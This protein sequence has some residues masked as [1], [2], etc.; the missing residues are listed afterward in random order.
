M[1]NSS[2]QLILMFSDATGKFPDYPDEEDGGSALLFKEKTPEEVCLV[3]F[4]TIFKFIFDFIFLGR[5]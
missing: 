3:F 2:H 4:L 5:S 1:C